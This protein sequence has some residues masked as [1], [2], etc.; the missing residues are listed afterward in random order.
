MWFYR[1]MMKFN[2]KLGIVGRF[3]FS[4]ISLPV[5][6]YLYILLFVFMAQFHFWDIPMVKPI[7]IFIFAITSLMTFFM[8]PLNI[9]YGIIVP[10]KKIKSI[11]G[12][13]EDAEL[14]DKD[15]TKMSIQ[16]FV[17]ILLSFV[18]NILGAF[19]PIVGTIIALVAIVFI[20]NA[21]LKIGLLRS[22]VVYLVQLFFHAYLAVA[23]YA[24][25]IYALG[26]K[27]S[28]VLREY[29]VLDYF[30]QAKRYVMSL[31]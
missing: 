1:L 3:I 13:N 28:G 15:V 19:I 21:I 9:S 17:C 27:S 10:Y 11:Y 22:V 23:T 31:F 14:D 24:V 12:G 2:E 7:V 5:G 6:I 26:V 30:E 29:Q 20:Y 25:I 4:I 8:Y 18:L 16:L